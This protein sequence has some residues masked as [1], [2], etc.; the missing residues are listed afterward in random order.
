[1][2]NP[3]KTQFSKSLVSSFE[4][5]P[6]T[7]YWENRG[8]VT[9]AC[10][11]GSSRVEVSR[12]GI[13]LLATSPSSANSL[14]SSGSVVAANALNYDDE[15]QWQSSYVLTVAHGALLDFRYRHEIAG[16]ITDRFDLSDATTFQL[17]KAASRLF[18]VSHAAQ[19][20]CI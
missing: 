17:G 12:S 16:I 15:V 9:E 20:H 8:T 4:R 11:K 2:Q 13:L 6:S 5:F 10:R 3:L 18:F 19:D 14:D 1:M 7:A